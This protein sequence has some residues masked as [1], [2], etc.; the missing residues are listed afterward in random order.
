M[1]EVAH[2]R[3]LSFEFANSL[4]L[5]ISQRVSKAVVKVEG[6]YWFWKLV[7]I[8]PKNVGRIVYGVAGPVESFAISVG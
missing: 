8:S 6:Y 7:E 4:C 1:I 3:T 5:V 2:T